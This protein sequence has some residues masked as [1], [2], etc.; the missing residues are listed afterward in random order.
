[1]TDVSGLL[2]AAALAGATTT[3]GCVSGSPAIGSGGFSAK[4]STPYNAGLGG[5]GGRDTNCSGSGALAGGGF[6]VLYFT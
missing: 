6:I 3:E 1:M 4:Y 2:A 5:G